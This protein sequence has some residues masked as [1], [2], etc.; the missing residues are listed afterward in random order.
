MKSTTTLFY[1]VIAVFHPWHC[2]SVDTTYQVDDSKGLGRRFDGIGGLS[3]GGVRQRTHPPWPPTHFLKPLFIIHSNC[4]TI[5]YTSKQ[6]PVELPQTT[7]NHL[8]NLIIILHTGPNHPEPQGPV[9]S[10][11]KGFRGVH[12]N[13]GTHR[14]TL[15]IN[16]NYRNTLSFCIILYNKKLYI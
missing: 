16:S 9:S 11:F 6:G 5:V 8:P 13:T 2:I 15:I 12:R 1:V 14:N 3:G 7:P 4:F 10:F